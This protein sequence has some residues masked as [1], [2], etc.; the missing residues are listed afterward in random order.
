MAEIAVPLSAAS[1]ISAKASISAAVPLVNEESSDRKRAAVFRSPGVSSDIS[2]ARSPTRS[3]A[4]PMVAIAIRMRSPIAAN[5]WSSLWRRCSARSSS[6]QAPLFATWRSHAGL[7][8]GATGSGIKRRSAPSIRHVTGTRSAGRHAGPAGVAK[9]D[10]G[11]PMAAELIPFLA[12]VSLKLSGRRSIGRTN[13]QLLH[14]CP[15]VWNSCHT[16][17]CRSANSSIRPLGS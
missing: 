4:P 13:S 8:L 3:C 14:Q 5:P 17:P 2:G 7:M 9:T 10:T 12:R 1:G 15:R 6:D 11:Q 16:L